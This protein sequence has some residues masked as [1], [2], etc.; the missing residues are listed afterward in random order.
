M[1]LLPLPPKCWDY[2]YM[3][4]SLANL[5]GLLLKEQKPH[6]VE[7]IWFAALGFSH[8]LLLL[9]YSPVA[10]V[11]LPFAWTSASTKSYRIGLEIGCLQNIDRSFCRD[12]RVYG[13]SLFGRK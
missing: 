11:S 7:G 10:Q 9:C 12:S 13:T 3:P 5:D 2:R 4:P 8:L 1:I 6:F